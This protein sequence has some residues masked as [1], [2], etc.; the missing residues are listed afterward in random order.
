MKALAAPLLSPGFRHLV[1]RA[2]MAAGIL[3]LVA[4]FVQPPPGFQTWLDIARASGSWFGQRGLPPRR[5]NATGIPLGSPLGPVP[6][7]ITD[8]GVGAESIVLAGE[9]AIRSNADVA[10][11][12]DERV[13]APRFLA[14]DMD[15]D[16]L[17]RASECL[18]AAAWYEAGDDPVGQRAVVQV[19]L[20][21]V[22]HPSYPATVCDVVFQ[23]TERR[24]GCQFTFTCDGSMTKRRPGAGPFARARAIAMA[25]LAGQTDANVG[26]ATH[27]HAD[28][29]VPK[30]RNRLVKIAMVGRHVFY[31]WAGHWGSARL[32]GRSVARG[33]EP[34]IA[35]MAALSPFHGNETGAADALIYDVQL[36]EGANEQTA[37]A[38]SPAPIVDSLVGSR[39]PSASLIISIQLN[40]GANPG[41]FAMH[42]LDACKGRDSCNVLGWSDPGLMS[43]TLPLSSEAKA[44]L[45]FLYVR[46]NGIEGIYWNCTSF[47]RPDAR[48]C[49]PTRGAL[50]R[51]L[52]QG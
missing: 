16:S 48:Q 44:G 12:A 42:A 7:A 4:T 45:E 26:T 29:V 6:P 21:R 9:A 20:N 11:L 25:A 34:F 31:R 19:V 30:W 52:N 18:A 10:I 36:D 50:D 51:L 49:M 17:W 5:L 46:R 32:L 23:G 27:Y 35:Q 15:A 38:R 22:R 8:F 3:W 39:A 43:Q 14:A 2:C 24:T 13:V 47:L 40:K 1:I 28:Y 37:L 41:S 33:A